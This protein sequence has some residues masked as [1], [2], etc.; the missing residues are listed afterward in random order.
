MDRVLSLSTVLCNTIMERGFKVVSGG[1]DTHMVLID[2]CGR[3]ETGLEIEQALE[4]VGVL[5]NRNLVPND[6]RPPGET[7]GL[8]LGTNIAAYRNLDA[9]TMEVI[10]NIICDVLQNPYA[11]Q[12]P[13]ARLIANICRRYPLRAAESECV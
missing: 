8:R 11:D 13:R 3:R 5:A 7:S 9:E 12:E 2:L 1:T 4:Q 10:G 6:P